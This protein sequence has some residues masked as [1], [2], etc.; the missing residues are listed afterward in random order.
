MYSPRIIPL[1]IGVN[2]S[3]KV[4]KFS[5]DLNFFWPCLRHSNYERFPV[6]LLLR[7]SPQSL[8]VSI[9]R[10]PLLPLV[11]FPGIMHAA[12]G[13]FVPADHP[14]PS[15]LLFSNAKTCGVAIPQSVALDRVLVLAGNGAQTSGCH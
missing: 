3:D 6:P 5:F 14:C 13:A 15:E 1:V 7:S 4:K 10:G 11:G 12:G 2:W 9:L 8:K